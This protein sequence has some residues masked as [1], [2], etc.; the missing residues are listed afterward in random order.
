M[1]AVVCASEIPQFDKFA[2]VVQ[3]ELDR[4]QNEEEQFLRS[5]T[6][7]SSSMKDLGHSHGRRYFRFLL[8]DA[9]ASLDGLHRDQVIHLARDII[10]RMVSSL[11]DHAPHLLR[12]CCAYIM[13]QFN[14]QF[15]HSARGPTIV[16]GGSIVLRIMCPAIIKPDLIGLDAHPPS[17]LPNAILLAKLLQ[18][19]MRGTEFDL[20]SDELYFAK[21]F[22]FETKDLFAG[23]L[24]A[25]PRTEKTEVTH[26]NY[27]EEMETRTLRRR[28]S[29]AS[30]GS[31][32]KRKFSLRNLFR[33]DSSP[34]KSTECRHCGRTLYVKMDRSSLSRSRSASFHPS[35]K[36]KSNPPEITQDE[37]FRLLRK[38][39]VLGYLVRVHGDLES[40][41][42]HLKQA[43]IEN[44]KLEAVKKYLVIE[45]ETLKMK[46]HEIQNGFYQHIEMLTQAWL[47]EEALQTGHAQIAAKEYAKVQC[48][49]RL[50][51]FKRSDQHDDMKF[52]TPLLVSLGKEGL[53]KYD[54][55]SAGYR[56][57]LNRVETQ[58]TELESKGSSIQSM[59]RIYTKSVEADL[60][61]VK[62]DKALLID[63]MQLVSKQN[64]ALQYQ[65]A[66]L[67]QKLC[68][69][70][71]NERNLRKQWGE[72]EQNL[73]QIL[74][75]VKN[76]VKK[77][78]GFI[79]PAL[80]QQTFAPLH[81]P[82]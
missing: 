25:F 5:S 37:Y 6:G 45:H 27:N 66:Q 44:T 14:A 20:A 12:L 40:K 7:L 74:M 51:P 33:K 50:A 29:Q 3:I 64:E 28:A 77:R 46:L 38:T 73:L 61:K 30:M 49:S 80:Q 57:E 58:A 2:R 62:D 68:Q 82:F 75:S 53:K 23:Y 18:H 47:E 19:S 54:R 63:Q 26:P 56:K 65:V 71:L 31:S 35:L 41:Q 69:Q 48:I 78:F 39:D 15:P 9:I 4:V 11:D 79:P 34:L 13:D 81:P 43:E 17:A 67:E 10:H 22:V 59:E 8:G 55:I 42:V 36:S 16:V 60:S 76:D 21:D 32:P 70:Q 72:H 24:A 52:N 1:A